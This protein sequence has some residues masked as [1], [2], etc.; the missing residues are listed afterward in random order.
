MNNNV[1]L[2]MLLE[3]ESSTN[4]LMPTILSNVFLFF[5]IFGL[6]AMVDINQLQQQTK[7]KRA[8]LTG[9]GMQFIVMPLLGFLIM[10]IGHYPQAMAL[11]LLVVTSSPGGSYSNLWCSLFNADLALSVTMTAVS[12]VLSIGFLPLNLYCYTT[13]LSYL[14]QQMN[15]HNNDNVEIQNSILQSLNFGGIALSLGIVIGA[16]FLGTLASW[17]LEKYQ[18]LFQKWANHC[19]TTSGIALI[20]VSALLSSSGETSFWNQDWTFYLGVSLPCLVGLVV[21]NVVALTS[22]LSPPECVA[23]AIECC[24]QN[25][26]IATSVAVTLF[27]ADARAQALAVPLCYGLVQAVVI[28]IY[29]VFAWKLGWTQA[30]A[31][32]RLCVVLSNNY[33][34]EGTASDTTQKD[35]TTSDD[36]LRDIELGHSE[37]ESSTKAAECEESIETTAIGEFGDIVIKVRQ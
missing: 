11:T 35:I 32:E 31:N 29:C 27:Q 28:G 21:A 25:T 24:Y 4:S 12:S 22:R 37:N 15:G 10:W 1:L 8:L 36:K 23:I 26:G 5:L 3:D 19:A 13:L 16:I 17:C 14:Q 7:K 9:I 18:R 6:S 2:R 33:N 34:N 20:L 30:P